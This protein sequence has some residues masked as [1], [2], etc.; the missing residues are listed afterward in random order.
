MPEELIVK[1][2]QLMQNPQ[3]N[4]LFEQLVLKLKKVN[5]TEFWEQY[6]QLNDL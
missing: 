5:E 6:L 4:E 3:M 2:T 1:V